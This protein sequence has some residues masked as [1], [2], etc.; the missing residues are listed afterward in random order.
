MVETSESTKMP[1]NKSFQWTKLLR[2][3]SLS[4]LLSDESLL[5]QGNIIKSK[6]KSTSQKYWI[7]LA[8]RVNWDHKDLKKNQQ[9][10]FDKVKL[11]R[12]QT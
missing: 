9:D 1:V 4:A 5:I 12:S 3:K 11:P 7:V 8:H 10:V 2:E 6:E